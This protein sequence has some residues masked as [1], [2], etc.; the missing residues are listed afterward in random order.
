MIRRILEAWL[1]VAEL[2]ADSRVRAAEIRAESLIAAARI[3][4][5]ISDEIDP[6]TE[7]E[8][9]S[10][11]LTRVEAWARK[12]FDSEEQ[13]ADVLGM[14]EAVSGEIQASDEDRRHFRQRL[15]RLGAPV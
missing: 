9:M 1:K 3:G 2:R 4:V 12:K 15:A 13:I 8:P 10:R 7:P 5:G 14:Y 11:E 6:Y